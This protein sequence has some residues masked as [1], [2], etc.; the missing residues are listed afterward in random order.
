MSRKL[1]KGEAIFEPT[2]KINL[3]F[4]KNTKIFCAIR[5][6]MDD[7]TLTPILTEDMTGFPSMY[8]NGYVANCLLTIDSKGNVS[9]DIESYGAGPFLLAPVP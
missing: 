1:P 6:N 7:P 8:P 2:R 3:K 4:K 5:V 9:I